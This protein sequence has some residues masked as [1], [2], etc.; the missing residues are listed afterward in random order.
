[1]YIE[2]NDATSGKPIV[3]DFTVVDLVRKAKLANVQSHTVV[4]LKEP[5][6]ASKMIQIQ[7]NNIGWQKQSIDFKYNE[8]VADLS[9]TFIDKR[10]DTT[11]V[12]FELNYLKRGD[13]VTLYQVFFYK[14]ASIMMEK[15]SYELDQVV[16]LLNNNPQIKIKIHGHTNGN[17][18]GK[19][20]AM[21]D[22][23]DDDFFNINGNHRQLIGSS[24]RLSK[25]KS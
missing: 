21:K 8:S 5:S 6:S 25:D 9:S 1:M 2:A 16:S 4:L 19:I 14:N 13:R 12:K 10:R 11:Y 22:K 24:K 15:S 17:A 3:I 18:S 7:S 20:I 23:N